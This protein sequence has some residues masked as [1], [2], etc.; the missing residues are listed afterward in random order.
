MVHM[1]P[2]CEAACGSMRNFRFSNV[3][4]GRAAALTQQVLALQAEASRLRA[5]ADDASRWSGRRMQG[6]A[7][8]PQVAL[9]PVSP[10]EF[11]PPPVPPLPPPPP[12]PPPALPGLCLNTCTHQ[13]N[14]AGV[15]NEAAPG[16]TLDSRTGKVCEYATDC[17]D[18]GV[19]SYCTD[20]PPACYEEAIA[21]E[22]TTLACLQ[23]M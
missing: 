4:E 13:L 5:E 10:P 21:A 14:E 7:G 2:P 1:N 6:G 17:T 22:P 11:P 3:L 15:C 16:Q 18:C 8:R 9:V 19:R 23:S 12:S 20:C